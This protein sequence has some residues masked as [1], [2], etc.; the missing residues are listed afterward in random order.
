MEYANL[1][2]RPNRFLI[3]VRNIDMQRGSMSRAIEVISL[4]DSIS[5]YRVSIIHQ[6]QCCIVREGV[7]TDEWRRV[8]VCCNRIARGF[9]AAA[10]R[11][12]TGTSYEELMT[13]IMVI[14]IR[15]ATNHKYADYMRACAGEVHRHS[16]LYERIY[17]ARL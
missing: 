14:Y 6:V 1:S 8:R 13:S 7:R 15:R 2:G 12:A 10:T 4:E 9:R 3:S 5:R 16:I 17:C 11:D